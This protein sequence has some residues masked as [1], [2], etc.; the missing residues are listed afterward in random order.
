[1]IRHHVV[2][3]VQT[4]AVPSRHATRDDRLA[5]AAPA[6]DPV[7]VPEFCTQRFGGGSLSVSF[8]SH[9]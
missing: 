1:M 2:G 3:R 9:P 6:T 7:D 8:G 4:Q 5:C